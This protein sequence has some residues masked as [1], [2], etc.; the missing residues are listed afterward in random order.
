M[1]SPWDVAHVNASPGA[2][3]GVAVRIGYGLP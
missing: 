3:T 2:S 1:E